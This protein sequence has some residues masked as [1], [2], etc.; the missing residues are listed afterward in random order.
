[1]SA[2][3]CSRARRLLVFFAAAVWSVPAGAQDDD[4]PTA[5]GSLVRLFLDGGT[6]FRI[7][8]RLAVENGTARIELSTRDVP[9]SF[10]VTVP[11]GVPAPTVSLQGIGALWPQDWRRWS[12]E[13]VGR[14]I[15]IRTAAA[16]M[17]GAVMP[18]PDDALMLS[19]DDAGVL[20]IPV[21]ELVRMNWSEPPGCVLGFETGESGPEESTL[22]VAYRGLTRDGGWQPRYRLSIGPDGAGTLVAD[23]EVRLPERFAG[24]PVELVAAPL[25][26]DGGSAMQGVG[27][28][29]RVALE[30]PP[31][32]G[33]AAVRVWFTQPVTV[34]QRLRWNVATSVPSAR[35]AAALPTADRVTADLEVANAGERDWPAG[36]VHIDRGGVSLGVRALPP[37]ARGGTGRIELGEVGGIQVRRAE[38]ELERKPTMVRSENVDYDYVT[39]TGTLTLD[40]RTG[41]PVVV[42]VV[43]DFPGQP[44]AAGEDGRSERLPNVVG[45][46]HPLSRIEWDVPVPAGGQAQ[47]TYGYELRLPTIDE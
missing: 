35:D 34:E 6:Q 2:L 31:A 27:V 47:R 36:T 38:R 39:M 45:A 29:E 5:D 20:R 30:P 8:E 9:G 37:V 4:L 43:K 1:M 10:S 28:G 40:N 3:S 25:P 16:P 32:A 12:M 15:G 7:R 17:A 24:R 44:I 14:R 19:L 21:A 23:A 33:T 22:E 41:A 46:H 42:R 18:G 26:T 11:E 13:H